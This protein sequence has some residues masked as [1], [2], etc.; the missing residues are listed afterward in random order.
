MVKEKYTTIDKCP[1]TEDTKKHTYLNLGKIPLVNNLCNTKEESLNCET[2]DLKVNYFP[3]SKLSSLSYTI[4]PEI[5]YSNYLYKSGTSQPYKDHCKEMYDF[6]TQTVSLK[7]SDLVLDIGGNDGTLLLEF[8]NKN[9]NLEYLNIDMSKNLTK[10]CNDKGINALNMKFGY[11]NIK[12]KY[13]P[14]SFKLITTTNC[15]QHTKDI[16][17]FVKGIK[18]SLHSGGIWCLEFPY[19]MI[20]MLTNQYDQVYHEHMYYYLVEP[21]VL[22]FKKYDLEIVDWVSLKIHGGSLRLIITHDKNLASDK[23]KELLEKEK[24]NSH[25]D[26]H[27]TFSIKVNKHINDSKK[28]LQELKNQGNSIVGFGAA[29]KGCIFLNSSGIDYN[30]MDCIIDDTNLKQGKFVPGTGIQITSRKYL[31]NNQVDVILILAHNFSTFIKKS[32]REEGY[33]GKILIF[34]PEIKFI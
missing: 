12:E 11:N 9:P 2:F 23:V 34:Y 22:L 4:N 28:F 13:P 29:A 27:K 16:N 18:Y 10:E 24:L 3:L 33:K 25:I 20:S 30:V 31:K 14:N 8:K 32:L 15:F 17:S 7:K 1:I 5:L 21:L 6:C 19:W 26:F